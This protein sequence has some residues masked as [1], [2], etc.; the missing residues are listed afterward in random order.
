YKENVNAAYVSYLT[1]LKKWQLQ[2]GLRAEQTLTTGQSVTLG[3]TTKKQYLDWFPNLGIQFTRN[4]NNQIGFYYRKSI[5]RF[6]F[7]YVNPFIIYQ[8]QYAY[9]M[10]NP[11]IEPEIYH[12]IELNYTFKQSY[13]FSFNYA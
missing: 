6:G 13:A 4:A 7:S 1:N 2:T 12:T 8:N 5:E 3:E 9:T 11:D 10:G